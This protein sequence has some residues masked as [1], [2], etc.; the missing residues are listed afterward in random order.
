MATVGGTAVAPDRQLLQA[1]V[2][3]RDEAAFETLVRRY[4]PMVL[5]VCRRILRAMLCV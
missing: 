2:A 4:G 1:F 3:M 5:G